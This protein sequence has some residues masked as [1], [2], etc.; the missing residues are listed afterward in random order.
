MDAPPRMRRVAGAVCR[1]DDCAKPVAIVQAGLCTAHYLRLRRKG[2]AN[3]PVA[4]IVNDDLTRFWSKI[5]KRGPEECWP[6]TGETRAPRNSPSHAYGRIRI[7]GV[8]VTATRHMMGVIEGH[9]IADREVC[10]SCDN[11]LCLNPRHL[12]LGT[13]LV[14][15]Q[16]MDAKGRCQRARGE[17]SGGAKLTEDQVR[18]IRRRYKRYARTDSGPSL[19]SEYGVHKT[20]IERIV[21]RKLWRHV[22]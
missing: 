2:D 13:H 3:A 16:D 17:E 10:H 11:T 12:F 21:K 20:T 6:W 4:F 22:A 7:Q 1:I 18:E 8:T 19:A 14:N 9:D 5:A 15:I